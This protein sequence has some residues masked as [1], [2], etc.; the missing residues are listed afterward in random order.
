MTNC[1]RWLSKNS[2]LCFW[3]IQVLKEIFCVWIDHSSILSD[4][5]IIV[6]LVVHESL[7][8]AFVYETTDFIVWRSFPSAMIDPVGDC[9]IYSNWLQEGG[10]RAFW[11][12]NGPRILQVGYAD[13]DDPKAM[14]AYERAGSLVFQTAAYH[15][16]ILFRQIKYILN[17]PNLN[18]SEC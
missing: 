9:M 1:R 7:L 15:P 5:Q 11:S 6:L 13:E 10:R 2:I 18:S 14:E 12:V 3:S 4:R 16:S 8:I 17:C